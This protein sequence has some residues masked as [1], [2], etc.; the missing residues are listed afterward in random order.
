M[1]VCLCC[2]PQKVR[3]DEVIGIPGKVSHLFRRLTLFY[4]NADHESSH[5]LGPSELFLTHTASTLA[6]PAS[7]ASSWCP[8]SDQPSQALCSVLGLQGGSCFSFQTHFFTWLSRRLFS[9]PAVQ[10]LSWRHHWL[11]CPV[12]KTPCTSALN[13]RALFTLG[14]L[15][16]LSTTHSLTLSFSFFRFTEARPL[17]LCL[18]PSGYTLFLQ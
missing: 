3:G 7:V 5:L 8:P 6:V 11:L 9:N 17:F 14:H 16:P 10:G 1:G 12:T 15:E 2:S 4:W 13:Q 18:F